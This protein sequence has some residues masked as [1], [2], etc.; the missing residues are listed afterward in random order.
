[1]KH[2]PLFSLLNSAARAHKLSRF[3]NTLFALGLLTLGLG[4]C[5]TVNVN[6]P[7]ATVQRA[8]GDYVEELYKARDREKESAPATPPPATKPTSKIHWENFLG[9]PSA[10]AID[11]SATFQI[12][13]AKTAQI[14]A[15]QA[16]RLKALLESK[17]AGHVGE[18]SDGY[19]SLDANSQLKP[20][21]KK[22]LQPLV[23]AENQ[24]RKDL[25]QEILSINHMSGMQSKSIETSFARSFQAASP[26]GTWVQSAEGKWSQKP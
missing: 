19:I 5:V 25:Y 1:M 17:K 9:I 22:S 12:K 7:E 3:R 2:L 24:D 14:Q 10:H 23:D 15:R 11:V 20:L 6:F 21:M 16:E 8:A 4:A 26:S 18:T 13:S